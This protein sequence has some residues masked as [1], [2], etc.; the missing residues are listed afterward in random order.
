MITSE[1]EP[2]NHHQDHDEHQ[3]LAVALGLLLLVGGVILVCCWAGP[4]TA[5]AVGA[6]PVIA[7]Y[8]G[9]RVAR[10]LAVRRA[11]RRLRRSLRDA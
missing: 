11:V 2:M 1:G 10:I 3:A 7:V 9:P 6:G 4:F 5:F 8:A